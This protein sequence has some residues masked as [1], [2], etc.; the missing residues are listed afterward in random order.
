MNGRNSS[1]KQRILV[2]GAAGAQG[3][4]VLREALRSEAGHVVGLTRNA[5]EHAAVERA[6]A[7]SVNGDLDDASSLDGALQG[8]DQLLLTLPLEYDVRRAVAQ[9]VNILDAAKRSGVGKIVFNTSA[10]FPEDSTPVPAFEI[11]RAVAHHL[12]GLGVP[13][14]VVRPTFYLENLLGPWTLPGMLAKGGD[15]VLAYPLPAMLAAHWTHHGDLARV[16]VAALR[17]AVADGSVLDIAGPERTDGQALADR[18]AAR[19]GHPIR[20]VPIPSKAFEASLAQALGPEA[21]AGVAAL[22]R[23]TEENSSTGLFRYDPAAWAQL[24]LEPTPVDEWVQTVA[25][26]ATLAATSSSRGES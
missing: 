11:K 20:Y 6:G 10:R 2:V 19:V 12:R 22:Y 3:Q 13:Y 5:D 4:A 16:M 14:V 25:V 21:A 23:W 7:A 26:P 1:E 17:T 24:H 9:G 15:A 18:F 8:I